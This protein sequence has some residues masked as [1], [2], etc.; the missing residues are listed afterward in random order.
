MR[1]ARRSGNGNRTTKGGDMRRPHRHE[2]QRVAEARH[3][4]HADEDKLLERAAAPD[5]RS[6][7]GTYATPTP[8]A[9]VTADG[10]DVD[11]HANRTASSA[12]RDGQT[13][14]SEPNAYRE[15]GS[16]PRADTDTE[17]TDT[18]G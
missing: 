17:T 4:N 13:T 14:T 10:V 15:A 18:P 12:Y 5:E 9:A 3:N 2:R 16:V 11:E 1:V 6:T 8:D 7:T